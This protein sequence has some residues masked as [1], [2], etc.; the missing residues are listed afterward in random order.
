MARESF[1]ARQPTSSSKSS[2]AICYDGGIVFAER[3]HVVGIDVAA[4]GLASL[5]QVQ[6]I[7]TSC[8]CVRASVKE[9]G[10]GPNKIILVVQVAAD[11]K[12]SRNASLAV[13]IEAILVDESKRVLSFCFTHVATPAANG[14]D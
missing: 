9:I 3:E 8:E 14:K 13:E 1:I 12:M 2:I 11:T 4:W 7:R 10:D 6:T 5:P